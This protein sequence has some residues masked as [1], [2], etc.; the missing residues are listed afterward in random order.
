LEV[1]IRHVSFLDPLYESGSTSHNDTYS[2]E[3]VRNVVGDVHSQTHV[4]KVEAVA[5]RNQSQSDN[6]VSDQL[7]KVFPGLLQL[8]QEHNGLLRPVTRLQQV[9]RLEETFVLAMR[10][11]LEHGGRVEVPNIRP[12]H[13]IQPKWTKDTKVK[14]SVDLLHEPGGLTLSPDSAPHGQRTDDLLHDKL[15]RER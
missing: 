15:A 10:E 5:Q 1:C 14:R 12:A 4:G 6:V 3:K 11:S 8:Q 13:D 7:L 9:I 2:K